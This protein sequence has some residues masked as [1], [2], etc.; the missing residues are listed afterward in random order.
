MDPNWDFWFENEQFGNPAM[1]RAF[2]QI[3]NFSGER[4]SGKKQRRE[5]LISFYW[6]VLLG[7]RHRKTSLFKKTSMYKI[8]SGI[9][10]KTAPNQCMIQCNN[11][12]WL[13]GEYLKL[14]VT[15][16]ELLEN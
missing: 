5:N 6:R 14:Q 3:W 15:K 7:F 10:V 1:K 13:F 11:V 4:K 2:S 16:V 9:L 8:I 12:F